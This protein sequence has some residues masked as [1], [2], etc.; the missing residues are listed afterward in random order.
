MA[1]YELMDSSYSAP[2]TVRAQSIAM[3][4]RRFNTSSERCRDRRDARRRM[5]GTRTTPRAVMSRGAMSRVPK[6]IKHHRQ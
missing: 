3:L 5:P 4:R 1:V 2:A 6:R